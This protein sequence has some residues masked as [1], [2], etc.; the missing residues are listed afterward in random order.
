LWVC[1]RAYLRNCTFNL[2]QIFCA[3]YPRP[4]LGPPLLVALRCVTSFRFYGRRHNCKQVIAPRGRQDGMPLVDGSSTLCG[5]TSVR[6]RV[7]SPHI[8]CGRPSAGSQRA[9]SL[10]CDRQR[11]GQTDGQVAVSFNAPPPTAGGIIT[12]RNR[13]RTLKLTKGAGGMSEGGRTGLT[14]LRIVTD[15]RGATTHRGRSLLST[16]ALLWLGE[17][18]VRG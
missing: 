18:L 16:T 4:W 17:G 12:A 9:D 10:G 11:E 7:R 1:P 8:S 6:G 3:R 5:S 15:P 14:R 2:R 13:R